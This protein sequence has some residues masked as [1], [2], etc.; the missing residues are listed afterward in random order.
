[1]ALESVRQFEFTQCRYTDSQRRAENREVQ[2]TF[3]VI[4]GQW[5]ERGSRHNRM[6]LSD[7]LFKTHRN[8]AT[9]QYLSLEYGQW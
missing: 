2:T 6:R 5:V 8:L 9:S 1:M 4:S 3:S 7:A